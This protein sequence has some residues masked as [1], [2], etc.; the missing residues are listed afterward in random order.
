[1]KRFK[2]KWVLPVATSLVL[3]SMALSSPLAQAQPAR[4][5][6]HLARV[7]N[8][9]EGD[10][11][12]DAQ[13]T[14]VPPPDNPPADNPAPAPATDAGTPAAA[15]PAAIDA[16]PLYTATCAPCHGANREGG[17]C[18]PLTAAA[19]AGKDNDT[20]TNTITNGRNAMPPMGGALTSDQIAA[21]VNYLK[22]TP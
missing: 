5:D 21:L 11:S 12:G 2:L 22:N 3:V 8:D 13:A 10:G 17:L 18:P 9:G 16:A 7:L 19:L 20:L 6:T 1:M 4:Q 15:A 14:P